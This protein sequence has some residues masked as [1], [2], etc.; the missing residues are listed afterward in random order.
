[1]MIKVATR[2]AALPWARKTQAVLS[3]FNRS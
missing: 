3:V 1:M 2:A